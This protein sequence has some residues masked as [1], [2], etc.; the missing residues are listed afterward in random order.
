MNDFM[1][2]SACDR[3]G[4]EHWLPDKHA[5]YIC[6][7]LYSNFKT[8]VSVKANENTRVHAI[9]SQYYNNYL[10]FLYLWDRNFTEVIK[11]AQSP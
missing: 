9:H 4:N 6:V 2:G 10:L 1:L 5:V 8:H 7:F 11:S 3:T